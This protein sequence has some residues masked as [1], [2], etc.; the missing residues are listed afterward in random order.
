MPTLTRDQG[1]QVNAQCGP[2]TIPLLRR[3]ESTQC[4]HFCHYCLK[5]TV[6][7]SHDQHS[8]V[9]NRKVVCSP[10]P[11]ARMFIAALLV[12][13]PTWEPSKRPSVLCYAMNRRLHGDKRERMTPTQNHTPTPRPSTRKRERTP[14]SAYPR[15][16]LPR[17]RQKGALEMPAMF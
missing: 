14:R 7:T 15:D 6:H 16:V 3:T 11:C 12:R 4:W 10:K 13:P 9:A 2:T 17:G 5:L 8:C 1:M